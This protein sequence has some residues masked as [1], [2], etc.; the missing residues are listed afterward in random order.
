MLTTAATPAFVTRPTGI[1][2]YKDWE[3]D[4]CG[5]KSNKFKKV[6]KFW[7]DSEYKNTENP[8]KIKIP[9]IRAKIRNFESALFENPFP[10]LSHPYRARTKPWHLEQT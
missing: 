7:S 10:I 4:I 2:Q 3:T 5:P 9:A 6:Y 8:M 1:L